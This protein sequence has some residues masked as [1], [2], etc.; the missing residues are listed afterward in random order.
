VT[1]IRGLS[2]HGIGAK[3][4]GGKAAPKAARPAERFRS[5]APRA[6]IW[7]RSKN[8]RARIHRTTE[9]VFNTPGEAADVKGLRGNVVLIDFWTYRCIFCN[10]IRR[11]PTRG[12]GQ[13]YRR[14]PEDRRVHTPRVSKCRARKPQRRRSDHTEGIK[15]PVVQDNEEGNSES[16]TATSMDGEYIHA[17]QGHVRYVPFGEGDYGE[18]KEQVIPRVFEGAGD[19]PGKGGDRRSRE[20]EEEG[21]TTPETYLGTKR[22]HAHSKVNSKRPPNE[23]ARSPN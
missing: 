3:R 8:L 23:S 7:C 13:R 14:R 17:T 21:V 6:K 2:S 15:Y 19:N 12:M 9:D 20:K 10:C 1:E 4:A 16:P 18:K 5:L 11:L 22:T